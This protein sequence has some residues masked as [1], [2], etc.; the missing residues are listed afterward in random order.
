MDQLSQ[1]RLISSTTLITFSIGKMSKLWDDMPA[2]NI[3]TTHPSISDQTFEFRK[4]CVEEVK[5]LL[6]SINNVKTPGSDILDGK[7]L[8]I[9]VD[10]VATPI[11]QIFNFSLLESVGT[12]A[13]REGKV[14]PLP[15]NSKAP[16]PGSN[17]RPNSLL[18]TLS[19]LM[20]KIVFDQIQC[21][22][23]VN[24]ST[25][26]TLIGKDTQLKQSR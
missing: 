3:D 2:T 17:S 14:I 10:D 23:T 7:L 19:K 20:G 9:I 15:K 16:F 21:Y 18:P 8:R 4:V 25:F 26:S 5:K 13:W 6:L 24:K 1:N 12:Q 22:F 11:C